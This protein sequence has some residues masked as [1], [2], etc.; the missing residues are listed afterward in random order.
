MAT[1]QSIMI[2]VER[3]V[4]NAQRFKPIIV[5]NSIEVR[6][7]VHP[8]TIPQLTA[9]VSIC[10]CLD[11]IDAVK[12]AITQGTYRD[13]YHCIHFVDD[14]EADLDEEWNQL[15]LLQKV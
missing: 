13:L 12:E 8:L 4:I 6:W 14:W 15:F 2:L 11:A 5:F 10:K 9:C 7:E 3:R 1:S